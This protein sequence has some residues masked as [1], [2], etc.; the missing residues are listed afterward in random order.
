MKL[1]L[2]LMLVGVMQVSAFTFAQKVTLKRTNAKLAE[3]LKD[4]Q[5]QSGYD[6]FY[7]KAILPANAMVNIN[8]ADMHIEK[9]LDGLLAQYHLGCKL[10]DK[11]IVLV[12]R[13]QSSIPNTIK[14]TQT[15]QR[16]IRGK[17]VNVDGNPIEGV[18]VTEKGGSNSTV[19]D[20]NGNYSLTL[21]AT[22]AILRF[23]MV[24]YIEQEINI[25]NREVVD[26][27]LEAS[28]DELD[29]V[30]VVGYGTQKKVNLTGSVSTVDFDND[31]TLSRPLTNVSSALSG[32]VPGLNVRQS[33]GTPGADGSSLTLRGAT[34]SG[35]GPYVLIDGM[36]GE[37]SSLS[38]NDIET[39]TVL[40][41]AASAAIY[42]NRAANGVILITT[43]R[44]YSGKVNFDYN[45]NVG[46]SSPTN[47]SE[48]IDNTAD[49][50]TVINNILKNSNQQPRY[51]DAT[52]TEWLEGAEMDPIKYPNTNWWD[53]LIKQN[54]LQ[55]HQIAARGGTD[56]ISYYT[57]IN[58][59]NNDGL[60]ANSAFKS[61]NFR[62]TLEYQINDWLKVGNILNA[63]F[64]INEPGRL[65]ETFQ[66]FMATTPAMVPQAPDGRYG[67][68]HTEGESGANNIYQLVNSWK[69][70]KEH[71]RLNANFFAELNPLE[72]LKI[73][74][75]YFKNYN[76]YSESIVWDE[77]PR[78]NFLTNTMVWS[79]VDPSIGYRRQNT[80][81]KGDDYNFNAFATYSTN[82][83]KH[84][85]SIMAGYE[86]GLSVGKGFNNLRAGL[87]SVDV[88]N[89]P[90]PDDLLHGAHYNEDA[91]QSYF[92]RF[93]YGFQEK[94]LLELNMRFDGSSRFSPGNRWGRFPSAS[95]G[96][97]ISEEDFWQPVKNV[98]NDLKIRGSW[99]RLGNNNVGLYATRQVYS[100]AN[101]SFGGRLQ[102]GL[103]P[104]GFVDQ[105]LTWEE[106]DVLDI[107]LDMRLFNSISASVDFYDRN[108]LK[109][110]TSDPISFNNGTSAGPVTN[111][112]QVRNRGVEVELAY[113]TMFENGLTLNFQLNGAYN[114]NK[115]VKYKGADKLIQ[116][117]GVPFGYIAEGYP[118]GQFYIMQV[119][120]I[121]Q[122]QSEID[123]L[124]SAGYRF[125]LGGM[126]GVG[127]FLFKDTYG[128]K[129]INE[130]D[131]VFIG[132]AQPIF[133]YGATVGLSYKGLDFNAIL[134]GVGGWDRYI[135]NQ[136]Y[137]LNAH[138][139]G[140]LYPKEF[141]HMST[142]DN[143]N[144]YYPKVYT[145][146]SKNELAIGSD[147]HLHKADFLRVKNMQL[148]YTLPTAW[149]SRAKMERLRVFANFENFFTFTS[150]PGLDPEIEGDINYP[151]L[152]TVSFG[153][154]L[155]F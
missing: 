41:D 73:N 112:P 84:E 133:T 30:V 51:S 137:S 153:L 101:T 5:R 146:N 12:R 103:V 25:G 11:S 68:A 127:D 33:S 50:M 1:S 100:S 152:K 23:S 96:W 98:V 49:Q 108:T 90:A 22:A 97:R 105:S 7:D 113:N 143:P 130:S 2:I 148:G 107:G 69:G 14:N 31:A 26:V 34:L 142:S 82:L 124:V 54:V 109:I 119:D 138:T 66:W 29:E 85:F 37:I 21:T 154:N 39:V 144:P 64:G 132:N 135:Q 17:I 149:T 6:I 59:Q 151:L 120:R 77:S 10:V 87:Y 106:T 16:T 70:Y 128:D 75:T 52:I 122:A 28:M 13:E 72:G 4:I 102:G 116:G 126:P 131:R 89:A 24:G 32:L 76:T 63:N 115:V 136:L 141:L 117:G 65:S 20:E 19:T 111:G 134:S 125:G 38:P 9:V 18:T 147:W 3:V 129:R 93:N 47:L 91:Y 145:N 46:F 78:W 44:G 92:S 57:S 110:L 58:H 56:K 140:Y 55:T 60:I 36:P 27:S 35:G 74:T 88:P 45:G 123:E 15:Q 8:V 155:K 48:I 139:V 53:A 81:G 67:A 94:Y 42:G 104:G 40:K 95:A 150:F 61:T 114:N 99:G 121:I 62:N 86:Q 118:I 80:E 83:E 79:G 43:K 71:R